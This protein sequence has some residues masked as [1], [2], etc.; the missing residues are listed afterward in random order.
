MRNADLIVVMH[1]GKVV[2]TG[3]HDQLMRLKGRYAKLYSQGERGEFQ[4]LTAPEPVF[5]SLESYV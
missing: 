1:K 2:E 5:E 3:T 4:E